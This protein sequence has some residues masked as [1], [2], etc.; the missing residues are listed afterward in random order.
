MSLTTYHKI[1][2]QTQLVPLDLKRI[3]S[4]RQ[5]YGK[6]RFDRKLRTNDSLTDFIQSICLL[7]VNQCFFL[8]PSDG[9]VGLSILPLAALLTGTLLT[10]GIGVLLVVVLAIRRKR[11]PSQRSTCDDKDKHLGEFRQQNERK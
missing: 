7:D 1:C 10:L 9:G 5:N 3:C 4:Q 11:D 2:S 6:I 8:L